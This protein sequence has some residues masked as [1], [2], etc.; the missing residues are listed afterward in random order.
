MGRLLRNMGQ[1][2]TGS[3]VEEPGI[4]VGLKAKVDHVVQ[5]HCR[6]GIGKTMLARAVFN[7]LHANRPTQP[8]CFLGVDPDTKVGDI[9]EKQQQLLKELAR[10]EGGIPTNA[11]QGRQLLGRELEGK[12][13]LLV[14]D[15]VWG[16]RQGFLLLNNFLQLL[17]EGSGV[18]FTAGR[19]V[20]HGSCK[21][22]GRRRWSACL[23]SS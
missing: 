18:L 9:K 11:E 23:M 8:C 20:L 6:G 17:G 14:V 4:K 12:R 21:G 7:Q 13:V 5:L 2:P 3:A 16:D 19:K 10:A 22:Q 15:T 1:M